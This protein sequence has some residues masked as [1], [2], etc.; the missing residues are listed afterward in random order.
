MH[1][2]ASQEKSQAWLPRIDVGHADTD[3]V[4]QVGQL[5][6]LHRA[7]LHALAA[8]DATEARKSFS[9]SAPGGRRRFSGH[10]PAAGSRTA[11]RPLRRRSA[12]WCAATCAGPAG[13]SRDRGRLAAAGWPCL[14]SLLTLLIDRPF[15]SGLRKRGFSSLSV[16]S[17]RGKGASR[18]RKSSSSMTGAVLKKRAGAFR[19]RSGRHRH[20]TRRACRRCPSPLRSKPW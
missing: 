14:R 13:W 17:G 8:L 10:R 2:T 15:H 1:C 19:S 20:T 9:S 18:S 5:D 4:D 3:A 16:S 12:G 7:D 11:R 6:G